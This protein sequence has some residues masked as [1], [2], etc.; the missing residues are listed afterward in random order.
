MFIEANADYVHANRLSVEFSASEFQPILF[1]CKDP[2]DKGRVGVR[3]GAAE[4]FLYVQ[5][6]TS[7]LVDRTL[8]WNDRLFA[9]FR[10][11]TRFGD[12]KT[13]LVEQLKRYRRVISTP[14]DVAFGK[15]KESYT[16]KSAGEKDDLCMSLQICLHYSRVKRNDSS[17]RDFCQCRG[18][19]LQ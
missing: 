14:D 8:C 15:F 5:Q 3:S 16:G 9:P 7:V 4:K 10:E 2:A 6:L 13:Q 18:L 1:E 19:L 17:F 12:T 11:D